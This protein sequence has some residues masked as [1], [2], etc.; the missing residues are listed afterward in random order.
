MEGGRQSSCLKRPHLDQLLPSIEKVE[1][2]N[3]IHSVVSL[4][5]KLDQ[6]SGWQVTEG[7]QQW[8]YNGLPCAAELHAQSLSYYIQVNTRNCM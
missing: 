8:Y 6:H 3:S 2:Q 7:T 4:L 5:H 1:Q